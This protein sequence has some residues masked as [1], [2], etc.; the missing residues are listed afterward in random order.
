MSLPWPAWTETEWR[1]KLGMRAAAGEGNPNH[2]P[3]TGQFTSGPGGSAVPGSLTSTDP[4]LAVRRTGKMPSP[5]EADAMWEANP[6]LPSPAF[7]RETGTTAAEM[8]AEPKPASLRTAEDR[9]RNEPN[10]H[11]MVLRD[12][13]VI[14]VFGSDSPSHVSLNIEQD[15]SNTTVTHNHPTN[16]G[17]SNQDGVTAAG[18]NLAEMRAVTAD[19]VHIIHRTGDAWPENFMVEI[20]SVSNEVLYDFGLK[21]R[22][23]KITLDEANAGHHREVYQRLE[24]R[25][26]GFTYRFE[27]RES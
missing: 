26:G 10:E 6:D 18:R 16:H 23:K 12:G 24:K 15:L 22:E 20:Q 17:L 19:G 13:R 25:I 11:A 1:E 3:A 2:D 5:A 8:W 27:P 9:I 4:W 21:L 7:R 14:T